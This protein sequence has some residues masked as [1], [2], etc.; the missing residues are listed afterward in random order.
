MCEGKNSLE[1]TQK[2]IQKERNFGELEWVT[3]SKDIQQ[4]E[5]PPPVL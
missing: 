3:C 5:M 1:K 4:I 2:A